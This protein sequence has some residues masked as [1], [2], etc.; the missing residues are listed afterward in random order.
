MTPFMFLYMANELPHRG[1]SRRFLCNL[2][3][4]TGWICRENIEPSRSN[5]VY[6]QTV[7]VSAWVPRFLDKFVLMY[8]L[9]QPVMIRK[10]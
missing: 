10:S 7:W 3:P 1:G 6:T 9:S 4:G 5:S 8:K 2:Y